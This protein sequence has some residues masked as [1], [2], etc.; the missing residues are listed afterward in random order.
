MNKVLQKVGFLC[1]LFFVFAC[2]KEER[3]FS[4]ASFAFDTVCQIRIFTKKSN[5][6]ADAILNAAFEKL[7]ELEVIFS[8]T[9]EDSELF[10]LNREDVGV[11][12]H[13]SQE[14][15]Y[16]I[17]EN[18]KMASLTN[19]K[20]NPCMGRLTKIWRE[21]WH[22]PIE[23][24]SPP[25]PHEIAEALEY[26]DYNSIAIKEDSLVKTQPIEIDLGASAKGYATDCLE[27]LL[28]QKGIES[29]I[30]DLGGNVKV[31]GSK[32]GSSSW[33]VGLKAPKRRSQ[34]E[35]AG[36]VEVSDASIVSS[37]S[38]ERCFEHNGVL[39]HHII[40]AQTG[41]PID[42]EL[43]GTSVISPNA[44]LADML[45]T[46]IFI[47]GVEES[48]RLLEQFKDCSAIFFYKD[49]RVLEVNN[50]SHPLQL[51]D[52]SFTLIKQ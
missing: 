6:E 10:K 26:V 40:S 30:I 36:Y 14:L 49:G 29:A 25:S 24:A 23:E 21:K 9:K 8:P 46:A 50:N 17:E 1:T 51:I 12:I 13:I 20:F 22:T 42:N 5:T 32:W 47:L 37:G 43:S 34:G 15:R 39:Y 52:D 45:S 4:M 31:L 11:P 3:E 33:K 27:E 48:S 19:G 44:M 16:I 41:L 28:R 18:L 7:R 2:A 35:V 38:Y